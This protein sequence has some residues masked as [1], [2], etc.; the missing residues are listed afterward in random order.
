M[1]KVRLGKQGKGASR[2]SIIAALLLGE[3]PP[4]TSFDEWAAKRRQ[5]WDSV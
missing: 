1:R 5:G 4:K 2:G 3:A